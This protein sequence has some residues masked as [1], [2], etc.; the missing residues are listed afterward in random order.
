MYTYLLLLTVIIY[1][2]ATLSYFKGDYLHPCAIVMEVFLVSISFMITEIKIWDAY[3]SGS[4]YLIIALGLFVYMVIAFWNKTSP[5]IRIHKRKINKF[6]NT[7]IQHEILPFDISS[8]VCVVLS[9]FSVAVVFITYREI[10]SISSLIGIFSS[11]GEMVGNYRNA[12]VSGRL[13]RGISVWA[14]YGM[15][16]VTAIAYIFLYI[17]VNNA[18]LKQK[19]K[20]RW[21]FFRAIPIFAHIMCS[22]ITGSRNPILQIIIAAIMLAYIMHNLYFK[23]ERKFR[24]KN[25]VRIAVVGCV[26][27]FG[28][29]AMRGIV[30]RES[31]LGAWDYI[32]KYVGAPIK[33]FDM[34]I[35]NSYEHQN[36]IW[37]QET[38]VNVWTYIGQ[39]TGNTNL[40]SLLM[41]KEYR[42][43]NGFSLGNVYTAF[44]EYYS[45]FKIWGVVILTAI[46]SL[47]YC[48]WYKKLTNGKRELKTS[49]LDTSLL[50]FS[51]FAQSLFYFSI[52]DRLYQ[53]YLSINTL[54]TIVIMLIL[55]Y[56][57]PKIRIKANR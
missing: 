21:Y 55:I 50:L 37:G 48:S 30:G 39:K 6:E 34:F 26:V 38:F 11:L 31:D 36:K 25:A 53:A 2:I 46:H 45:D 22:I 9:V 3:I 56:I 32:A 16:T 29:S 19:K 13:E 52:D 23:K 44:R 7:L 10:R 8:I 24:L 5:E 33:L 57:L 12:G 18:V 40:S 4:T 51:Y 20:F 41:N 27:L 1:L 28:F 54:R 42:S 15:L 43:I 14:R 35:E 47:V 17:I 49:R